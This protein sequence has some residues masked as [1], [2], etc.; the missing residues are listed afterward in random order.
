MEFLGSIDG[1]TS[2]KVIKKKLKF[3]LHYLHTFL[4]LNILVVP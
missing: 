1:R 4:I 2:N 3:N